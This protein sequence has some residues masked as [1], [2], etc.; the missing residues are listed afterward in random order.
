ML[1]SYRYNI[2]TV[3]FYVMLLSGHEIKPQDSYFIVTRIAAVLQFGVRQN[4][5]PTKGDVM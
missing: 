4:P 3:M 5:F 2:V 1:L